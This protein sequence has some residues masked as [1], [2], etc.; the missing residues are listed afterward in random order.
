MI[1]TNKVDRDLWV[2]LLIS[3]FD[4]MA[5]S[6]YP[7][8]RVV[9]KPILMIVLALLFYGW[10]KQ[11]SNP[12]RYLFLI[13]LFFAWLGDVLLLADSM[14]LYGLGAFLIMQ[15]LY[16]VLFFRD[17][18]YFGRREVI[19]G[20]ILFLVILIVLFAVGPSLGNLTIAFVIYTA[21]IAIMSFSSFT[22]D[23]RYSG[24]WKVF[25]GATLFMISDGTLAINQFAEPIPLG[26]I[27]VMVTYLT[28]QYLISFGYAAYLN[29]ALTK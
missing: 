16:A 2:Y 4:I 28:A 1:G 24:Y 5:V 27:I 14:F 17:Q 11:V 23:F 21:T 8:A 20:I 6:L 22:R 10:T 25:Y 19:Y 15:I 9:S 3:S 7:A 26:G 12:N 13:A 29:E 18:N